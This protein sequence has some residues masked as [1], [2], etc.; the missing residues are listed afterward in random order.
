ML[1]SEEKE[2]VFLRLLSGTVGRDCSRSS[3]VDTPRTVVERPSV[4]VARTM[5]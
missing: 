3:A 5:D 2:F 4:E 1:T